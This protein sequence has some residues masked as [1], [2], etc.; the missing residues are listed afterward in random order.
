MSWR[1]RQSFSLFPGVRITL[2]PGGISTSVGAGPLRFTVGPRGPAVTA[3]IPGTGI[4]FRQQLV[5]ADPLPSPAPLTPRSLGVNLPVHQIQPAITEICSAESG[6]LTT[7]GLVEFKRLLQ[8]ASAE[9]AAILRE[10]ST[11]RAQEARDVGRYIRWQQGW[12]FKHLFKRKFEALHRIAEEASAHRTELEE[13]EQLARLQTHLDVPDNVADTFRHLCSQ[14][15]VLGRA[16]RVW[17]T[18]GE[19]RTNQTVERTRAY[20]ALDRK[21]VKFSLGSCELIESEWQVPHLE[22]AN[23]G[24]LYLY[25]AFLLY[26]VNSDNFALLEYLDVQLSFSV[27]RFHEEEGV[28]SDS[29]V[30]GTTWA[31]TNKDGSPDKRFKNNYEIPIAA[32]GQLNITSKTGINEAYLISNVESTENFSDAWQQMVSAVR[33]ASNPAI[34]P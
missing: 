28:P 13:Q 2:S 5:H 33:T 1:F 8:Q 12:L 26:V 14:F 34:N 7:P 30:V 22:N 15:D 17:D 31:K 24:D 11:W 19:R 32:Y 4:A 25:P 9:R 10:L 27:T 18:V 23:G 29:Q 21:L 6:T 20:R 3:R 16:Q